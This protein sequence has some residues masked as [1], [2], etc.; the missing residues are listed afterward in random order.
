MNLLNNP[1]FRSRVESFVR[2]AVYAGA[3]LLVEHH[4]LTASESDSFSTQAVAWLVP[5]IM[6][7]AAWT[8]DHRSDLHKRLKLLTALAGHR[9]QTE[10]EVSA[11]IAMGLGAVDVKTPKSAVPETG[12]DVFTAP[13]AR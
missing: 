6:A 11:Q 7:G 12:L 13:P 8:W 3:G 4:V 10:H 9:P 1:W 2:A 5:A